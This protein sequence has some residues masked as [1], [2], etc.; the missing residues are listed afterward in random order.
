MF[1]SDN[2]TIFVVSRK[3]N[4]PNPTPYSWRKQTSKQPAPVP[5]AAEFKCQF[6]S[7]SKFHVVLKTATL[8]AAYCRSN[9]LYVEQIAPWRAQCGVTFNPKQISAA[10]CAT[11]QPIQLLERELFRKEKAL[12]EAAALMILPIITLINE[13]VETGARLIKA[14]D[15]LNRSIW[16]IQRWR[17]MDAS[18]RE[19]ARLV[20]TSAS[21]SKNED[22]RIRAD[23]CY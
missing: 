9:G 2:A 1:R 19:D 21:S 10:E 11:A 13:A 17:R 16:T 3:L 6:D 23:A 14:C 22:V 18:V 5:P 4:I 15:V 12:A 7:Q 20:C 8:L